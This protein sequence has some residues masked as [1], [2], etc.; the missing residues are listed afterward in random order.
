MEG[1]CCHQLLWGRLRVEKVWRAD[2]KLGFG[3]AKFEMSLRYPG[4]DTRSGDLKL[5][6]GEKPLIYK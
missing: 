4:D 5:D 3:Y 1:W 6:L 2:Q